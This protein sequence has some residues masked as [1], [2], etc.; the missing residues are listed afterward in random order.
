MW[1]KVGQ[2]THSDSRPLY[3]YKL[4]QPNYLTKIV[5]W[6]THETFLGPTQGPRQPKQQG[7]DQVS[8]QENVSVSVEVH[9]SVVGDSD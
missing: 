7:K 4:T 2:V 9:Y 1:T 3:I 6:P 8:A 5:Q